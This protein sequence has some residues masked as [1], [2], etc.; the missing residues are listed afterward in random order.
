V[1]I[2]QVWIMEMRAC[3]VDDLGMAPNWFGQTTCTSMFVDLFKLPSRLGSGNASVCCI[4]IFVGRRQIILC[5]CC[6]H[7]LF[8]YDTKCMKRCNVGILN[9]YC[10]Y[11]YYYYLISKIAIGHR[12]FQDQNALHYYKHIKVQFIHS[13]IKWNMNNI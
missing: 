6:D 8:R 11:C 12:T 7:W 10:Y 3:A 1:A 4:M 2:D 5:F 13:Q 9:K